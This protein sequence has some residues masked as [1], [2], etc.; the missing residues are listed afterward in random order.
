ME[1]TAKR[2]ALERSLASGKTPGVLP[3]ERKKAVS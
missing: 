1:E 3:K 2:G